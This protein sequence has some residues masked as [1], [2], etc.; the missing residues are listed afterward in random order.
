MSYQEKV[1]ALRVFNSANFSKINSRGCRSARRSFDTDNDDFVDNIPLLESDNRRSTF[2]RSISYEYRTQVKTVEWPIRQ[3]QR[4][5]WRKKK[6]MSFNRIWNVADNDNGKRQGY[7]YRAIQEIG[8]Y[9]RCGVR[10][11]ISKAV[12]SNNRG[13]ESLGSVTCCTTLNTSIKSIL[14]ERVS[15]IYRSYF[16]IFLRMVCLSCE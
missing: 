6:K 4:D 5:Y 13:D 9:D 16:E 8:N 1:T 10:N 7:L 3:N 12:L 11:A 15:L 14:L 2:G